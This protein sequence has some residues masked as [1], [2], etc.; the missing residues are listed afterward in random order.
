MHP[1]RNNLSSFANVSY[2]EKEK[3]YLK[4]AKFNL[5]RIAQLVASR[6]WEHK[7]SRSNP[8]KRHTFILVVVYLNHGLD[9]V[10]SK[11]WLIYAFF[12]NAVFGLVP[13]HW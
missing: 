9:A 7:V 10:H 4:T 6:L 5:A 2:L 13:K 3:L 12:T 1:V 11:R 8:G